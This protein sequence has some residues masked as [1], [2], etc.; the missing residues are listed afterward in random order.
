M[1]RSSGESIHPREVESVLENCEEVQEAAL[2]GIPDRKW[3]SMAVAC[4]TG[5]PRV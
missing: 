2:V 5:N 3:G 4:V 1:I